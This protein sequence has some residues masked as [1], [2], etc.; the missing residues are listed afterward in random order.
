MCCRFTPWR[1][2]GRAPRCARLLMLVATLLMW[3]GRPALAQ[4][5]F[6]ETIAFAGLTNRTAIEFAS[7]GRVFVAEKAGLIKVFDSI[8]DLSPD[9]VAD[10]QT[11]VHDFGDRGLWGLA[12][13]PD[14]PSTPY[15][16]VLYTYD[17][18]IGGTAPIWGAPG[19]PSD[20]CPAANSTG[21]NVSGRLSRLEVIGNIAIGVEQ[22][23]VEDWFQQFPGQSVGGLAFGPD[24]ALYAGAGDGASSLL[25][26]Q[27]QI[28]NP[29]NDP[30][31]E[32]GALRSQDLSSPSDPVTL[33]GSI[34]RVDPT[35]GLPLRRTP[36]MSIG[37]PVVDANGV[38]SFLVT[39]EFQGP[40]PT[41]VRVLEPT[42]P[43][44]DIP[45]RLL[46]VLPVDAGVTSLSSTSSDGLEELRLLDVPNRLN[47]TLIAPSFHI[48]PWY[49]D[50]DSDPNR[51]LES[52]IINDLVPFGDSFASPGTIPERWALGFSKSGFGAL[53]IILRH[54][55]VFSA[56]AAWDAPTEFTDISRFEMAGNFGTNA[57]FDRYEIP[58]LLATHSDPF[59]ALNRLWISGDQS[60]WHEH[61][62][63]LRDRLAQRNIL[64]TWVTGVPRVHSWNSGWL[65][66]AVEDMHAAAVPV[67]PV[68]ANAQRV[69]AFG[70]REP[71]RLAFRPGTSE[72]WIGDSGWDVHEEINRISSATDGTVE[73]FGWPCYE[74]SSTT[75]YAV[76][77]LCRRL[78]SQPERLAD[79][80]YTYAHDQAVVTGDACGAGSGSIS[81]L[82]F[83]SGASYPP[84]YRGALFFADSSR[85]CIWAM[86]AG[87]DGTPEPA[88]R[89]NVIAAS[90]PVDLK[91]GPGEN[92]Y[93]VDL[94]GGAIRRISYESG[95]GTTV[96][97]MFESIP[98]GL[99]LV[100]GDQTATT[101]FARTV[102][103]NSL[104]SISAASPQSVGVAAYEFSSWSDGGV[105]SHAIVAAASGA[106][107]ATFTLVPRST[108][109]RNLQAAVIDN[110]V[111]LHWDAPAAGGPPFSYIIEAGSSVGL[112]DIVVV[113]T[114][115]AV[116]SLVTIAPNG[117]YYVRVRA[118]S[119]EG[120]SGPSN[121][122]VVQVGCAAPPAAPGGLA[123][124]VAG[125]Q[126]TLTWGTSA[127]TVRYTVLAGSASG[128][129]N[130]ALFT[131]AGVGLVAQ[132]PPGTYFARVVAQ[133]ACGDSAPST[134]IIVNVGHPHAHPSA[135]TNLTA[136]VEGSMVTLQW[137]ATE[138]GGPVATY[139]LEVGSGP[140][141]PTDLLVASVGPGTTAVGTARPGTYHVR[142]R[143]QNAA[144]DGPPT[145]QLA[146]VV[147]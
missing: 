126:V 70:L 39:S 98:T 67:A 85:T 77:P 76:L 16:Y 47:L 132:A 81:G 130:L 147:P 30:P 40:L 103:V 136:S 12:L 23:L 66:G 107:T 48:E 88:S 9:I 5:G 87:A 123:A 69:I 68:D 119:P 82:T 15:L 6:Q 116:T 56:A 112:S 144:G 3:P 58:R 80:F 86:F 95:T 43:V 133:N 141:S 121:E 63:Q 137:T 60:A 45:R 49:G 94:V 104:V 72:I 57:N 18:P 78:A 84:M 54:P 120:T 19:V 113:S 118:L 97:L 135:P 93:Y 28:D 7:D 109:P 74:G 62:F 117:T 124:H 36:A 115:G 20:P 101:P 131:V 44:S 53:T 61:M 37:P 26:D 32:G 90:S 65:E 8:T 134:E 75:A 99:Q 22:V 128:L 31:G 27:G 105:Q 52:F 89:T 114:G 35:A 4:P 42:S 146:V 127:G 142:V 11:N 79:P 33:A 1:W 145:A 41:I 125:S 14:F 122:I 143:G 51:R 29:N 34:I 92:L 17:A 50:H 64:H 139:I 71:L 10:L 2:P 111:T 21:C 102:A 24:G 73:N 96:T 100:V 83:Y 46:Y 140:G 13:H 38:K 55:N 108:T 106:Y 110:Q 138:A 129:S 25:V 91:V 59:Q